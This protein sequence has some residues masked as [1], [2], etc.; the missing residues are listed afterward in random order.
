MGRL[1]GRLENRILVLAEFFAGD[2]IEL[3]A[4]DNRQQN[5]INLLI[6]PKPFAILYATNHH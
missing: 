3:Q 2:Q 6:N 5:D 1:R 4:Q